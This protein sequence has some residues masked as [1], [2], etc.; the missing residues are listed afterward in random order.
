MVDKKKK[1][2]SIKSKSVATQ[3]KSRLEACQDL[4][5]KAM[6]DAEEDRW[7]G[8]KDN[9]NQTIEDTESLLTDLQRGAETEGDID[10]TREFLAQS[11]FEIGT[12]LLEEDENDLEGTVCATKAKPYLE[13]ALELYKCQADVAQSFCRPTVIALSDAY[14]I[15]HLHEEDIILCLD[16]VAR[17]K[18]Q[19]TIWTPLQTDILVALAQAYNSVGRLNDAENVYKEIVA[20]CKLNFGEHHEHTT[21]AEAELEQFDE[22]K[23]F[24]V[25]DCKLTKEQVEE[26]N[27]R[28]LLAATPKK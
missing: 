11:C 12:F 10:E 16:I 28:L 8:F 23:G 26:R 1:G 15:L 14:A 6:L 17:L 19:Y 18:K 3:T 21:D 4:Y 22:E 24:G 27:S 13:R 20:L 2:S 9:L 25:C 7:S 5:E